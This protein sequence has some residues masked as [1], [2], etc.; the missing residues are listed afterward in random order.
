VSPIFDEEPVIIEV[1]EAVGGWPPRTALNEFHFSVEA[2]GDAVV[3]VNRHMQAI[4]S[5][6]PSVHSA[7]FKT[8]STSL[9][10]RWRRSSSLISG[11]DS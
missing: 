8:F 4:S 5:C 9:S 11:F 7:V 1:S 6:Q 10:I 3:F 2:L